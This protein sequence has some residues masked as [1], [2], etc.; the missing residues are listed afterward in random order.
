MDAL[1]ENGAE[2]EALSRAFPHWPTLSIGDK[3][4]AARALA[5]YR[6]EHCADANVDEAARLLRVK[7]GRMGSL[8]TYARRME[9]SAPEVAR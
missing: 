1:T 4:R 7:L 8:A 9:K 5:R 6:A 2:R 3:A